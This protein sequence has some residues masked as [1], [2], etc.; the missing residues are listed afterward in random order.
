MQTVTNSMYLYSLGDR[1]IFVLFTEKTGK[2]TECS[3]FCY[4]KGGSLPAVTSN[5]ENSQLVWQM[6]YYEITNTWIGL[7][8]PIFE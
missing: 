3:D 7:L 5:A 8:P 4:E 2:H 1:K 6:E